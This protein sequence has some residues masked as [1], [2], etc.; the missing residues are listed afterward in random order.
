MGGLTDAIGET[1]ENYIISKTKGLE[2]INDGDNVPDFYCS[3]GDF[4]IE[5]KVGNLAWGPRLK[6]YQVENFSK[7][8][9]PV[10]YALGFHDFDHAI[11]RLKGLNYHEM[12]KALSKSM[13]IKNVNFI[14]GDLIGKI[15]EMEH[16]INE[17]GTIT[18]FMAKQSLFRN[19]WQRR[20]FKRFG[21]IVE[22]A[23]E[24]YDFNWDDFYMQDQD[25]NK[26]SYGAMLDLKKDKRVI[27][28]LR[29]CGFI[30]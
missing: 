20:R 14:N 4:W 17:R 24:Y 19:I 27:D 21:G 16:R 5:A 8:K 25:T 9:E 15:W 13:N 1:F 12:M 29:G 22:F 18:Y 7:I 2:K 3:S 11:T 30:G 6:G 26:N 28:Y 23:E 10:I